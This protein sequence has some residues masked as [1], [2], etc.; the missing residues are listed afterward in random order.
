MAAVE[1][2]RPS[3]F[4]WRGQTTAGTAVL[5]AWRETGKRRSGSPEIYVRK[6]W[7]GAGLGN[8]GEKLTYFLR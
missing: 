1:P 3:E 8:D 5:R 7:Q 4:V 2:G 6:L